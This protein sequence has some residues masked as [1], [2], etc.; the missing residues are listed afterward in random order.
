VGLPKEKKFKYEILKRLI[1]VFHRRWWQ[2]VAENNRIN[3]LTQFNEVINIIEFRNRL[4]ENMNH[5]RPELHYHLEY[6]FFFLSSKVLW[7][8]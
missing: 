2:C 5:I 3:Y 1:L 4:K 7:E 8:F 6:L